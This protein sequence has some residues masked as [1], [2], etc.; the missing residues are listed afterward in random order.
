[1]P[2][3]ELL[4]K[5]HRFQLEATIV[6]DAHHAFAVGWFVGGLKPVEHA[7]QAVLRGVDDHRRPPQ[8]GVMGFLI[9]GAQG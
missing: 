4:G 3:D 1:M 2:G 8:R 6:M 7:Q 5:A 9:V